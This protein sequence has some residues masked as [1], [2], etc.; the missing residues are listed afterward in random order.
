MKEQAMLEH[1]RNR[2]DTWRVY[3]RTVYELSG[4]D[5]HML[6]DMGLDRPTLRDIRARARA[7]AREAR[8]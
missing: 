1:L 2:F 3:R 6:S 8:S 7:A 4:L 5:R